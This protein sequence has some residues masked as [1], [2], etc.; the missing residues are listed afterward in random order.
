MHEIAKKNLSFIITL[1]APKQLADK[2]HLL[3]YGVY[4][5]YVMINLQSFEHLLSKF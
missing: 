1:P 3:F 4:F 2:A 5:S